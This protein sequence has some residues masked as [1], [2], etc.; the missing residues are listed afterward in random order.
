MARSAIETRRPSRQ[1]SN[2]RGETVPEL[3]IHAAVGEGVSG[4]YSPWHVAEESEGDSR[5][6]SWPKRISLTPFTHSVH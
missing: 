3:F 1:G 4:G 5:S 2:L 6:S